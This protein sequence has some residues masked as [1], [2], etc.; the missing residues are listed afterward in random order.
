M[1]SIESAVV[2]GVA[3][4]RLDYVDLRFEESMVFIEDILRLHVAVY[5]VTLLL[6]TPIVL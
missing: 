6:T 4:V 5:K 3:A 2:P 1:I